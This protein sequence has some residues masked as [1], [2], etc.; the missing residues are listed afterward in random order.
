M[1]LNFMWFFK[2]FQ[3]PQLIKFMIIMN[4]HHLII[5]FIQLLFIIFSWISCH[6]NF[7]EVQNILIHQEIYCKHSFS[8]FQFIFFLNL[9]FLYIFYHD[10]MDLFIFYLNLLNLIMM[11]KL[12]LIDF[13]LIWLFYLFYYVN[14]RP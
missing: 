2:L 10:L 7:I 5:F 11:I 3:I 13:N 8:L 14:E 9:M 1:L 12:S 4:L 6:N